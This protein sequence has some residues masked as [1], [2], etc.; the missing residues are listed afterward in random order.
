MI[1]RVK[2]QMFESEQPETALVAIGE[3][4]KN[5]VVIPSGN[6]RDDIFFFFKNS[7]DFHRAFDKEDAGFIEDSV[8]KV[9]FCDFVIL[10]DLGLVSEEVKWVVANWC[11][12]QDE[13]AAGCFGRYFNDRVEAI[14]FLR[15][16][17]IAFIEKNNLV[18][19]DVDT[20]YA[21]E[22][23]Y[24]TVDEIPYSDD[25]NVWYGDVHHYWQVQQLHEHF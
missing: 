1:R 20:E 2:I 18:I 4:V 21:G 17:M 5:E 6:E 12:D 9:R 7:E 24:K 16:D 14:K 11:A 10:E 19:E 23:E 8:D 22:G 3:R 13:D 15:E 25:G